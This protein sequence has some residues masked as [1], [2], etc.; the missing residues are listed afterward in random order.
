MRLRF[1]FDFCAVVALR[2]LHPGAVW[3]F[4]SDSALALAL[5][6]ALSF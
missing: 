1:V 5:A 4:S 6:L 2:F 3:F